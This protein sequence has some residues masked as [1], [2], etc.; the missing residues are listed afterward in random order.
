MKKFL[1]LVYSLITV[2][3]VHHKQNHI[4][5]AKMDSTQ[6]LEVSPKNEIRILEDRTYRM[7]TTVNKY[8]IN[9]EIRDNEELAGYENDYRFRCREVNLKLSSS[10]QEYLYLIKR[11]LFAGWINRDDLHRFSVQSFYFTGI[12]EAGLLHFE[13]MLC[14]PDT[15]EAYLFDISP[16]KGN[17][18]ITEIPIQW[19]E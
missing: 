14:I 12:D 3:C 15:D 16:E 11:D 6:F 13:L 2:S 1:L 4:V 9:Y 8:H 10:N 19:E 5:T 7:D 17:L 18:H